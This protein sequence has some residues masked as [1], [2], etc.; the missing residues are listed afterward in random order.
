MLET[1]RRTRMRP[2]FCYTSDM[3]WASERRLIILFI[4]GVAILAILGTF[5][6][7]NLHR[8]PTCTDGVQN[9]GETGI[10]CGG[11][12]PYLCTAE[13]HAPIVSVQR[14]LPA[15][16][17]RVDFVSS[18]TNTNPMAATKK[19]SYTVSLFGGDQILIQQF[20]GSVE[21]PPGATVPIFIPNL[22]VGSQTMVHGFL[23]IAT[24]SI[25]WY[26]LPTDPRVV[27]VVSNTTLTNASSTPR[28][29]AV[30]TNASITSIDSMRVV[31]LVSDAGGNI[32]AA[33]QTVVPTVPAQ[34]QA[35]ATFTWNAPFPG[36][37]ATIKVIPIVP[38]P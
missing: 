5:L 11:P 12:C 36:T 9:Q 38:L 22:S 3:S 31:V 24:T 16:T 34:G 8:A 10:D 28:I 37:A 18:I 29:D 19:V 33:S 32:I 15:G 14:V 26:A 13:Q 1:K 20:D 2:A 21:L 17:G 23:T 6:Y 35:T 27:P 7:V 30:L 25:Q 4:I